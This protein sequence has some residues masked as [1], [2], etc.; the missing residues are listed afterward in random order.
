MRSIKFLASALLIG[1][2]SAVSS[3]QSNIVGD[4][5][6]IADNGRT[7]TFSGNSFSGG[8]SSFYGSFGYYHPLSSDLVIKVGGAFASRSTT[9]RGLV[10]TETGG[11]DVEVKGIWYKGNW[12]AAV[13]ASLPNTPAQTKAAGTFQVGVRSINDN[14]SAALSL[15]GVTSKDVSLMGVAAGVRIPLSGDIW[16][17][18]SATAMVRGGNTVDP[19]T[20][21]IDRVLVFNIGARYELGDGNAF[22]IGLGNK[23]GDTTGFSLTPRLGGGS[24]LQFG[25]EVRF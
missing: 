9:V 15:V 20:G 24:G 18:G 12:Y 10:A 21:A 22:F 11:T 2:V 17:D 4:A 13:G 16:I 25:A 5:L 8:E 3:A 14:G 7:V 23:L 6:F 1:G 19:S